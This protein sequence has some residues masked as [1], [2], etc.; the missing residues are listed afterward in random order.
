MAARLPDATF[1]GVDLSTAEIELG[2]Q[3][4]KALG[5]TNVT[6]VVA[7]LAELGAD[8]G[9]FDYVIAHGLYSW[10][11][12]DG[13]QALLTL[14]RDRL[15]PS[16]CA[17]VSWN[18]LPGWYR[19][20][21]VRSFVQTFVQGDDPAD[22]VARARD[23][24]E[25]LGGLV[26]DR[27]AAWNRMVLEELDRLDESHDGFFSAEIT[28]PHHEALE[29]K[30]FARRVRASGLEILADAEALN[31]GLTGPLHPLVKAATGLVGTDLDDVEQFVDTVEGRSF[32]ASVLVR[33]E[34][35]LDRQVHGAPMRQVR[36]GSHL[37]P[38]SDFTPGRPA[39][40]SS[41][42]GGTARV[43]APLVQC[44]LDALARRWPE[45]LSFDEVVS[46]VGE[47]VGRTLDAP[48][49]EELAMLLRVCA[50]SNLIELGLRP[51]EA[52]R[53]P[54]EH[55]EACPVA[56]VHA[57]EGLARVANDAHRAVP[58]EE[59]DH[60]ILPLLDGSSDRATLATLLASR[61]DSDDLADANL[62]P[63]AAAAVEA[64]LRRYATWG[65][66]IG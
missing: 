51:L 55:P 43:A 39:T 2:R 1:V 50:G 65:L 28:G 66:M 42:W 45:K 16:G 63:D 47:L 59:V 19:R 33:G 10:L 40:F 30:D 32:R 46:A 8:L 25:E 13:Q 58:L 37:A 44:T 9:E 48:L 34:L 41:P 53:L 38:P 11:P 52:R 22:R 17:Y 4:A 18:T 15:T 54:G 64:I 62:P 20:A 35:E 3:R 36:F 60:V 26:P 12:A 7:D 23:L 21:P 57:A 49:Q 14:L 5:L 27:L 29:F 24:L 6:L 56:R 61:L 31:P